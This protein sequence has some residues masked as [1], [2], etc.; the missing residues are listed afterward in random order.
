MNKY[1]HATLMCILAAACG[2]TP[3]NAHDALALIHEDLLRGEEILTGNLAVSAAD[4]R[5]DQDGTI[6]L[7]QIKLR[8]APL[9][10]AF[11]EELC[12]EDIEIVLDGREWAQFAMDRGRIAFT[13]FDLKVAK[14]GAP[15]KRSTLK[16]WLPRYWLTTPSD[17]M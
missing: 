9:S 5:R 16:C 7:F 10:G 15:P 12:D 4:V 13:A 8:E 2:H 11:D 6:S 17:Q 1:G 3:S 14:G